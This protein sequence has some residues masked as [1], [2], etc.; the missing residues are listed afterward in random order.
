MPGRTVAGVKVGDR[1]R[2]SAAGRILPRW[3]RCEGVGA[4]VSGHSRCRLPL[5]LL[6]GEG[7]PVLDSMTAE[8]WGSWWS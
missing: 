8:S 2:L 1:P 3:P 7:C 5:L 4:G 6:G